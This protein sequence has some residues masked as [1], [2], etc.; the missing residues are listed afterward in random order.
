MFGG[1]VILRLTHK[2]RVC[3]MVKSHEGIALFP[4]ELSIW[5]RHIVSIREESWPEE[6]LLF[7]A[8]PY[9]ANN[10]KRFPG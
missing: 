6:V 2:C 10:V 9:H 1:G 8:A 5:S 3:A 7:Q 4:F